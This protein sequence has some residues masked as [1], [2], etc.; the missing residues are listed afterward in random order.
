M[1]QVIISSK[2]DLRSWVYD[3]VEAYVSDEQIEMIVESLSSDGPLYG[4]DWRKFLDAIDL[5]E[6]Y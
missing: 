6:L 2:T 5:D 1:S 4:A 3:H